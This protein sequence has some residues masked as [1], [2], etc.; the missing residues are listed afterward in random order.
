MARTGR[1]SGYSQALANEICERLANSNGGLAEICRQPGMPNDATVYRW[2]NEHAEFRDLYAH[3]RERLADRWHAETVAIADQAT[4]ANLARLRVDARKWAASKLAPRKYGDRV[5]QE[6][7]GKDGG[8]IVHEERQAVDII[9][10]MLNT[11]ASRLPAAD[12]P[13]PASDLS[14]DQ[15]KLH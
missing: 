8:P 12:T 2:L 11:V 9:E 15:A 14:V 3:A 7:V 1:P 13:K 10:G 6:H 4:D 5:V